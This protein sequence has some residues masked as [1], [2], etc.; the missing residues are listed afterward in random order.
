MGCGCNK[1]GGVIINNTS[2]SYIQQEIVNDENCTRTLHDIIQL[3]DVL[4]SKKT[5]ENSGFINS[6][7]GLIDTMVNYK[8]YCL[9]NIESL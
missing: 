3:R 2:P 8:K 4:E 7:L 5:S 9:Y 6:Q 1:G